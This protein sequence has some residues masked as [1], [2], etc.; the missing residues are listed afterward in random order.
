MVQY[1]SAFLNGGTAEEQR[2]NTLVLGIH[3]GTTET[4]IYE[5]FEEAR[6]R[7]GTS[8][9]EVFVFLDEINTCQFMGLI[10]EV[11]TLH[12]LNGL[13]LPPN[14]QVLSALNP[15]RERTA[16]QEKEGLQAE[17]KKRNPEEEQMAKLVYK[18]RPIPGMGFSAVA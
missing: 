6:R 15:Y 11:I 3:G 7:A 13:R 4:D 18:V 12:S 16:E 2:Q 10:N 5:H 1:L 8:K 14:V 9:G 17:V